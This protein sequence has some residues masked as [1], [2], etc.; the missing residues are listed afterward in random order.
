MKRKERKALI[1]RLVDRYEFLQYYETVKDGEKIGGKVVYKI[2]ANYLTEDEQYQLHAL[3]I[4]IEENES[5]TDE[6]VVSVIKTNKRKFSFLLFCLK[7]YN[8]FISLFKQQGGFLYLESKIISDRRLQ[9]LYKIK[10][11]DMI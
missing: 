3:K 11:F 10:I 7:K 1:K 6:E 5:L 9:K 2:D 4:F 8:N